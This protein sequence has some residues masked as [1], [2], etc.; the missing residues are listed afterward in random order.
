[1]VG[2]LILAGIAS[3]GTSYIHANGQLIAKI[4][5][6]NVTYYH[7]DHLGSTSAVTNKVGEVVEKQV[8]LPFGELISGSEKYGFTSK[9][10]D[11]TELMYFGA[12]YYL[13]GIG[14]FITP[15][16]A[17]DGMNWY[18]YAVNNPLKFV[19]PTGNFV[20][21]LNF[22]PAEDTDEIDTL[23]KDKF[24]KLIASIPIKSEC[25]VCGGNWL[26]K[27][28]LLKEGDK[29]LQLALPTYYLDKK[30]Y[31]C[32]F[33]R[34]PDTNK[35]VL[36][37]VNI[38]PSTSVQ[39]RG[40]LG[41]KEV[42]YSQ[43]FQTK[44]TLISLFRIGDGI[45]LSAGDLSK[46]R[47]ITYTEFWQFSINADNTVSNIGF[48]GTGLDRE[49]S[50]ISYLNENDYIIVSERNL[51][52]EDPNKGVINRY[53]VELDADGRFKGMYSITGAKNL[54]E[55]ISGGTK[56]ENIGRFGP[57][58]RAIETLHTHHYKKE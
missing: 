51:N 44:N 10:L 25:S 39:V 27:S 8:N 31:G 46:N 38:P 41:K 52:E 42:S 58:I 19:D 1:M 7:S 43:W 18:S 3:A 14:K 55:K 15:D 2:I 22:I 48:Y 36:A 56:L 50:P 57:L 6:T 28:W 20:D 13:P 29:Y 47:G 26:V 5:E 17:K 9:E 23:I 21:R 24:P 45:V 30:I 33:G 34:N 49:F 53:R 32:L 12:R 54:K 40:L 37:L 4:N 16:A 35:R 11:E